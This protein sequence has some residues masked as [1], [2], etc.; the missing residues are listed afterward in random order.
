MEA[1]KYDSK[2]TF[3]AIKKMMKVMVDP[4]FVTSSEKDTIDVNH[5]LAKEENS[6]TLEMLLE[7]G[8]KIVNGEYSAELGID[9]ELQK[10]HG[11]GQPGYGSLEARKTENVLTEWNFQFKSCGCNTYK[12]LMPMML[13]KRAAKI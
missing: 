5:G 4:Q 7:S 1:H 6:L 10:R 8:V 2:E 13:H 9:R 3:P 11:S 12:V